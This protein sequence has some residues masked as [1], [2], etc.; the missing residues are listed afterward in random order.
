MRIVVLL[1]IE[2]VMLFLSVMLLI[3]EIMRLVLSW[4]LRLVEIDVLVG[5][6]MMIWYL[7]SLLICIVLFEVLGLG[8]VFLCVLLMFGLVIVICVLLVI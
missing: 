7:I 6:V 5:I 2:E 3:E 1:L 8:E 4:L